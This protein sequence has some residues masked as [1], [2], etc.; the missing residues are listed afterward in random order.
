MRAKDL[1]REVHALASAPGHVCFS[2]TRD[3][4]GCRRGKNSDF[5]VIS[6]TAVCGMWADL[7]QS[8]Q[9]STYFMD[10]RKTEV[11][12]YSRYCFCPAVKPPTFSD[13]CIGTPI[14]FND[15]R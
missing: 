3:L 6:I 1:D 10:S 7:A 15:C 5:L 12:W 14:R 9:R 2:L 13:S 4:H 8:R 11:R